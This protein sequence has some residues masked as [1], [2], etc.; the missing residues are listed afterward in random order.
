M[1]KT[2]AKLSLIVLISFTGF[3]TGTNVQA[4]ISPVVVETVFEMGSWR[5]L[6]KE[7]IRSASVD[8]ALSE[9]SKTKQFAFFMS[10]QP[11]LKT[12]NLKI[13]VHLV[14]EAETATVS[15]LL[16]QVNGISVSS[17]HSE[18]LQSQLYDGIYKKFQ[19]AG[20]IAGKK[21]VEVLESQKDSGKRRVIAA[22]D[23]DRVL[24]LE[25]QIISINQKILSQT[26]NRTIR[27]EAKLEH[28]LNE[29]K[30]IKVSYADLAK[31]EDIRKQGVKI[32]KVLDEVGQLSKKIDDKPVTQI[33][34]QQNYVISNPLIG[35]AKI[36]QAVESGRDDVSA[37]QLY[38]EAQKLKQKKKYKKAEKNLSQAL[39]L[40]TSS[41]LN[42]LIMDEL[43]YGLPMF[44]AQSTAIELGGNF[45]SYAKKGEDKKMLNRITY[46][47][48]TAL[49]N[50]KQDFQRTRT[51]QAALDQHLNTSQ[52]MSTAMSVQGKMKGH[53]IHQFMRVE[54]MMNGRYPDKKEFGT[55]LKRHRIKFKVVSYN[56]SSDKYTAVLQA[57][58]GQYINMSVDD[59]GEL[60]VE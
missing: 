36:P 18:S 30:T 58:A 2:K 34:V 60:T 59:S 35:Q 55:L 42:S 50:N 52:A 51:I 23:R 47:Y 26:G 37:R 11:G 33:N 14:E 45:Q 56:P 57:S 31:K 38:D 40:S 7:K 25:N 1:F 4:Q 27:S 43:N 5:P 48:E 22:Q 41:S 8:T 49:I 16:Q 29:L 24:Y 20:R 6:P 9:I 13:T 32:D 46:L 54:Y 19:S 39:S 53:Q 10:Q 17:T 21:L 28:I 12:G 44:E 15:I 3:L